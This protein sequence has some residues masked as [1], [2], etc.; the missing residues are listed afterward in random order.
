MVEIRNLRELVNYK[1][2]VVE[3]EIINLDKAKLILDEKWANVEEQKKVFDKY[4]RELFGCSGII[5]E[6]D[7]DKL[8]KELFGDK[9]GRN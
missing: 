8:E 3:S 7:F 9:D 4:K 2:N 5:T 1:I 6:E